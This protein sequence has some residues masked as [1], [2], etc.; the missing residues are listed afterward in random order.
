MHFVRS[1]VIAVLIIAVL[2]TAAAAESLVLASG[3][4]YK[5]MVNA[6]N[7]A[8][9]QKTGQTLDLIYGN[10]GRVTTLAKES[11]KVDIVLGDENFLVKAGLPIATRQ[12]LGRGKL[13][14]AFAKSSQF[15]KLE[16]LDKAGRIAMPDTKKA[17]YGKAARE[18]LQS[19]G[20]L[21]AIQPRLIEVATIPQV[22]SYL[23]TNEVDMG[24]LNLTHALNVKDKL[25]GFIVLDENAYSPIY[26]IAGVLDDC[27]DMDQAK[28]FLN[29]LQT[30]EAKKIIA[31]NGL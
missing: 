29:F 21:P 25:G 24:F 20:R 7:D 6:L 16:D 5:K 17:I 13:V 23:T 4:G 10:M 18:F 15:S 19:T 2:A 27:T 1:F 14:L 9:T 31:Q 3:A 22:F 11:G 12:K 28:S 30:P 26:I 8:Y